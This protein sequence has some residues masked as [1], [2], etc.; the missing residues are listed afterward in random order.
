MDDRKRI[1]GHSAQNI[2]VQV[3]ITKEYLDLLIEEMW[4]KR[5]NFATF[6]SAIE[7][8]PSSNKKNLILHQGNDAIDMYTNNFGKHYQ[9]NHN[10][11]RRCTL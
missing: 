1:F 8:L 10:T 6:I 9:F 3:F 11:E 5:D 4:R 2:P 7:K